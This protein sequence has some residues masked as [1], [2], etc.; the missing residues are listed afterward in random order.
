MELLVAVDLLEEMC[1]WGDEW[2]LRALKLKPGPVAHLP[3]LLPDD[4]DVELSST[5][6]ALC[7]P[8]GHHAFCHDENGLNL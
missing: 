6:P 2:V 7:L 4:P 8:V 3:F 1:H 5:S